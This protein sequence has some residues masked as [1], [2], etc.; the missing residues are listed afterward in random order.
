MTTYRPY[1]LEF[2]PLIPHGR[3]ASYKLL[4]HL[5]GIHPRKVAS[6]L[7]KNTDIDP[8]PCFKV[9]HS[10]GKIGGYNL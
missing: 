5:F 1:L 7:M 6:I 9:V 4:S 8:Y 3:V 10:D 2:L